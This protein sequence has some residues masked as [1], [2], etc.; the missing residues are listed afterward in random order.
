MCPLWHIPHQLGTGDER[1]LPY[2]QPALRF[3]NLARHESHMEA[4]K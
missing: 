4:L 2:P 3:R 1:E